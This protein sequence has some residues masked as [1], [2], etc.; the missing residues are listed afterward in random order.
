MCVTRFDPYLIMDAEARGMPPLH[1]HL[2]EGIIYQSFLFQHLEHMGTKKLGQWTEIHLRHDKE[3]AAL[4]E[5]AI[6]HQG[7]EVGVP[8]RVISERLNGHDDTWN[9][10]FLAKGELEEFRQTF[11]ST[12][13]EL[14]QKFAVIE[15]ESSQD[16]GDGEDILP[17][18]YRIKNRFLDR[19]M[20]K[21]I[22]DGNPGILYARILHGDHRIRGISV[23]HGKLLADKIRTVA[24]RDRHSAPRTRKSDDREVSTGRFPAASVS[25]IF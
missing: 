6:G 20:P 23:P 21:C 13:A 14:A 25:C 16:F 19:K 12:L 11:Y 1:Y 5:E 24:V 4:Q 3:I 2:Y 9:T 8:S 15:K 7:M 18:G 17:V 10:G 22:R